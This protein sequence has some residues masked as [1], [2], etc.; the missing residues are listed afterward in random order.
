VESWTGGGSGD[1]RVSRGRLKS[2]NRKG[3]PSL[4]AMAPPR[5]RIPLPPLN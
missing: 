5:V 2:M 4:A 1:A 3:S